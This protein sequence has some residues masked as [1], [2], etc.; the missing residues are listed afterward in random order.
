MPKTPRSKKNTS[1]FYA[2]KYGRKPGVYD[3]WKDA[4]AQVSPPRRLYFEQSAL[5]SQVSGFPG[6]QHHSFGNLEDANVAQS[7]ACQG[8][9]ADRQRYAGHS[10]K[11]E[12]TSESA[13]LVPKQEVENALEVKEDKVDIDLPSSGET[14]PSGPAEK[15]LEAQAW[16]LDKNRSDE[17]NLS[18]Q[19]KGILQKILNGENYFFTGSAGTG[20]SV[21]LRAIIKAF[22]DRE[23]EEYGNDNVL[24]E[25][26]WA[27]YIQAGSVGPAPRRDRV[28]RWQLGV[29]ASTGLAGV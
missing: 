9:V 17:P 23:I 28:R 29:T 25:R 21:L 20:K 6:A 4:E 10:V 8:W 7:P 15:K 1:K 22:K 24:M 13:M 18:E 2:V 3:N 12:A 27:D 5:I 19:Q 26:K 16:N 14:E 11:M